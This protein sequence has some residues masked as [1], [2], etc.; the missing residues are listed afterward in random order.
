[1]DSKKITTQ[2]YFILGVPKEGS[3][4]HKFSKRKW[5]LFML[6]DIFSLGPPWYNLFDK[7]ELRALHPLW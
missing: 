7:S 4:I 3:D 6:Q 5:V 2:L 1:M